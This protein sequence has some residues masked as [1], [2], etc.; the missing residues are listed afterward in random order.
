MSSTA[1]HTQLVQDTRL[2]LGRE[3]DFTLWL[4]ARVVFVKGQ[5]RAK[6]GLGTGSSDLIGILAPHGK[7]VALEAK[8]GN[9]TTTKEQK[10]FLALVR[11]RGGFAATFRSV[12]E[13][14][15]AVERARRG[16][17]Q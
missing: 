12:D 5:P 15:Q 2:A 3:E 11:K 1:E 8:T 13:A 4:N 17:S 6:P 16:E 10:Q 9:A 7:I 14:L